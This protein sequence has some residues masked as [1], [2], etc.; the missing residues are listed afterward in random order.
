MGLGISYINGS[1]AKFRIFLGLQ[2]LVAL[3]MLAGSPWMPESPR[4][5]IMKGRHDKALEVLRRLHG[6]VSDKHA[7]PKCEETGPEP[8]ESIPLYQREF[9]Q[10]EAQ[11]KLEKEQEAHRLGLRV[12]V[13]RKSYRW[14]LFIICFASYPLLIKLGAV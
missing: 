7:T 5:L 4:W 2:V 13:S 14:R 10:I 6:D 1:E 3:V 12:I 9:N 11:I 8:Y